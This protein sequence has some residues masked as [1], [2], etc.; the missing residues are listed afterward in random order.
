MTRVD[1]YY[2]SSD[3]KMASVNGG[4]EEKNGGFLFVEH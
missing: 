3:E 2:C 1:V 4:I